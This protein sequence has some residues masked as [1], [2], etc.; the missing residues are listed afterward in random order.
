M[1]VFLSDLSEHRVEALLELALRTRL[2]NL[3]PYI[4]DVRL[5]LLPY[6]LITQLTRILTVLEGADRAG[7]GCC[8]ES[9]S[10]CLSV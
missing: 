5:E 6:D 1:F 9:L 7:T 4:D 8:V 2:A 3:D 10:V